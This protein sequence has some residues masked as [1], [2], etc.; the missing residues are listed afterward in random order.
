[1]CNFPSGNF[2]SVRASE[3]PQAAMGA[4][5]CGDLGN[6][7]VAKLTLG[8]YPWEVAVCEKTFGKISNIAMA[9]AVAKAMPMPMP[10]PMPMPMPTR[11]VIYLKMV[12]V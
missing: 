2:P 4:E 10:I 11:N 6:C 3:T 5:R 7:P 1:M 12:L 9:M 8:K